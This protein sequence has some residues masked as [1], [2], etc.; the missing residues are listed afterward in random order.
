MRDDVRKRMIHNNEDMGYGPNEIVT[1]EHREA[2]CL[3]WLVL[4]EF[5]LGFYFIFVAVEARTPDGNQGCI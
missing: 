5:N 3:R 2:W 1:G 4:A